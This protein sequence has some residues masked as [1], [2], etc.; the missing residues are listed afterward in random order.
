MGGSDSSTTIT[1]QKEGEETE[2]PPDVSQKKE[3]VYHTLVD[4]AR[5]YGKVLSLSPDDKQRIETAASVWTTTAVC[6]GWTDWLEA[7]KKM[8]IRFF[9]ED[10]DF[11]KYRTR[12]AVVEPDRTCPKCGRTV[13]SWEVSEDDCIHCTEVATHEQVRELFGE[14]RRRVGQ[15]AV[16]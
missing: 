7:G 8:S 12:R 3:D 13:K 15:K 16:V 6:K 10:T 11:A 1:Q 14:L 4:A 2:S 9:C 5:V